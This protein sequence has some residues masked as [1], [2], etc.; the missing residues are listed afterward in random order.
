MIAAARKAYTALE[1]IQ[2]DA[3]EL[4]LEGPFDA[5]FSN[6]ALHWMRPPEPVAAQVARVLK[7]GGRFVAEM[8][9]K[10]N[11]E[12]VTYGLYLAFEANGLEAPVDKYPWYFPSIAEYGAVLEKCGFELRQ[13]SLFDR[14][15]ALGHG[16]PLRDW[17]KTFATPLFSGLSA[18]KEDD[19]LTYTEFA[20]RDSLFINERWYIDYRRL[21]FLAVKTGS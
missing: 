13:A 2:A 4:P 21:R 18:K 19:I 1:F 8:G 3:A 14:P 12:A 6:A 7:K 9:G 10:G 17:L 20:L 16:I 11:V 5:V 15:V